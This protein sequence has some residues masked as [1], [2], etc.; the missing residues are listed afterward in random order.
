MD[1]P[2]VCV[3]L[4][5]CTISEVLKD[6]ASA[7]AIGADLVEVRLDLLW[8][9]KEITLAE[10]GEEKDVTKS[11]KNILFIPQ[12]FNHLDLDSVL[13]SLRQ[14][15]VLPVILTCRPK[16]EG[17]YFP[18][19]EEQRL[20]VL[21]KAIESGV[22]WIDLEIDIASKERSKLCDLAKKGGT[23]IIASSHVFDD[24][25]DSKEIIRDVKDNI[26]AGD[27]IKICYQSSGRSDGINLFEAAWDLR[28]SDIKTSIMGVG[29]AGDWN[30]I[31]SP[32]LGQAIVYSTIENGWHLAQKG[33]INTA[34][35]KT[36]W[37]MLE[38]Q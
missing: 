35:L 31:H 37:E 38:Y 18:G 21:K 26:N 15:I 24:S 19:T 34:D 32:I 7:T 25:P 28:N 2:M 6:A 17:G 8:T 4:R 9:K 36:A 27:I 11:K 14:G 29:Q 20:E 16:K 13:I 12:D 22:S 23:K 3:T 30:R 33:M 5:G 10:V 1:M